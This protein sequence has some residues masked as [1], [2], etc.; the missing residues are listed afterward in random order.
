MMGNV[1]SI[2]EQRRMSASTCGNEIYLYTHRAESE[3]MADD[4]AGAIHSLMCVAEFA[5]TSARALRESLDLSNK[6]AAA[7]DA[8]IPALPVPQTYYRICAECGCKFP[9]RRVDSA[10]HLCIGCVI[11][12]QRIGYSGNE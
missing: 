9:I 5:I 3:L 2:T 12:Q 7:E 8:S 6:Q 4:I 10:S 11:I 1:R